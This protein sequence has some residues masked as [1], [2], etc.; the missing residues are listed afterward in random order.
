MYYVLIITYYELQF[1][2]SKFALSSNILCDKSLGI[3]ICASILTDHYAALAA[4][5][6][7]Y[8]RH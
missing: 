3:T 6:Y 5:V 8:P 2:F 7:T 4:L 1:Y